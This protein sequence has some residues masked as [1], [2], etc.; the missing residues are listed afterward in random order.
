MRTSPGL[1]GS[2]RPC[3]ASLSTCSGVRLGKRR[4]TL[5]VTG[6]M[7]RGG[8]SV[9][10]IVRVYARSTPADRALDSRAPLRSALD[11]RQ[12]V[13]VDLLLVRRALRP[14]LRLDRAHRTP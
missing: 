8:R 12:E 4:S 9:V 14:V 7:V 10:A 13:R 3:A 11:E 5:A 2:R 6:A 1:V